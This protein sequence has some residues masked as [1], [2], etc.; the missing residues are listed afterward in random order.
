MPAYKKQHFVPRCAFKPFSLNGEGSA[1]NVFNLTRKRAI[2]NAPVKGQCAKAYLYGADLTLEKMLTRLEGHYARIIAR[3]SAGDA[4]SDSDQDWLYLFAIV[5]LRRTARAIE[6]LREFSEHT[7]NLVFK[8]H[9][10]QAP[11]I[12]ALTNN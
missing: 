8:Y 11:K 3:L 5:Q 12:S 7:A 2:P 4:L 1:I 10:E 9:P 6:E